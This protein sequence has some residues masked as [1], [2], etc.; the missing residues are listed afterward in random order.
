MSTT[1]QQASPPAQEY[2]I[3]KVQYKLGLQD[4]AFSE[5][6]YHTV[7]FVETDVD[8]GGFI[9]H[10]TGDIASGTGMRYE[11]KRGKRPEQSEAFQAKFLL[12]TVLTNDYPGRLEA[13]LQAVPPPLRQRWFNPTILA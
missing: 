3:Y 2:Y 6:R 12:G 8:Q 4:P 10:V 9:H 5:T 7:I 1:Y 13:V 11:R